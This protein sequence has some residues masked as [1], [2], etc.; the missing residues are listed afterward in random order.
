MIYSHGPAMKYIGKHCYVYVDFEASTTTVTVIDFTTGEDYIVGKAQLNG[1]VSADAA[2]NGE[3][4]VAEITFDDNIV[5]HLKALQASNPYS[6]ASDLV[7][8]P[9][10]RVKVTVDSTDNQAARIGTFSI[11]GEV[12]E[13]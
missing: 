13:R 2:L 6:P 11:T 4:V 12:Y 8:P 10:T 5:V 1:P 7:I 3:N 9:N